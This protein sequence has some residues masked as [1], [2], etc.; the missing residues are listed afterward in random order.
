[1]FK[2]IRTFTP[3]IVSLIFPASAMA[4]GSSFNIGLES[5][6]ASRVSINDD[7]GSFISRVISAIII[8][9]GIAAFLYMIL[10]GVKWITSGGEKDKITDARDKVTQAIVGLAV[11]AAAWAIFRLVDYFFGIGITS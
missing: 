9:A 4:Q 10:G 6:V 2:H 1:M 7:L 3:L 8:M 11:V 5:Q